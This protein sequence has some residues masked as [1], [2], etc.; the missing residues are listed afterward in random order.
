ML[1]KSA[2][3]QRGK[4]QHFKEILRTV[5]ETVCASSCSC[6]PRSKQSDSFFNEVHVCVLKCESDDP[7]LENLLYLFGVYSDYS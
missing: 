2:H 7:C 6:T 1:R 4:A 5:L 3:K